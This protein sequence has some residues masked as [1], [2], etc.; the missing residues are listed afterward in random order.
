MSKY[1]NVLQT[2]LLVGLVYLLV[3]GLMTLL[4]NE[5]ERRTTIPGLEIAK[6]GS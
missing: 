6:R 3:I 4:L 2:Y 5:I 1:Y